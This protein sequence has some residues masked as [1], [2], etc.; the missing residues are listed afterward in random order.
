MSSFT[1]KALLEF[2]NPKLP[3]GDKPFV[4]DLPFNV[5]DFCRLID[6]KIERLEKE[7]EELKSQLKR[8]EDKEVSR[9][10]CCMRNEELVDIYR[11]SLSQLANG[12]T[13]NG[14]GVCGP[15]V[16]HAERALDKGREIMGSKETQDPQD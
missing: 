11:G 13:S 16:D 4:L 3:E 1:L 15:S 9:A 12:I 2:W 14:E 8:W 10:I 6:E 5:E 7:N